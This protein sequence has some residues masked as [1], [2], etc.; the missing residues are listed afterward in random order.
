MDDIDKNGV[1]AEHIGNARLNE[2]A[3]AVMSNNACLLN[4]CNSIKRHLIITAHRLGDSNPQIKLL[5][6]WFKSS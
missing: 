3:G 2:G 5:D 6:R 4:G 1:A